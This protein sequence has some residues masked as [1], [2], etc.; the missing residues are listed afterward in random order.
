M[1]HKAAL[2]EQLRGSVSGGQAAGEAAAA[3]LAV[4]PP[5]HPP[6]ASIRLGAEE[7]GGGVGYIM[8]PQ[9]TPTV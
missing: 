1:L 4:L 6:A 5:P 8:R 3:A 7:P 9:R 2:C